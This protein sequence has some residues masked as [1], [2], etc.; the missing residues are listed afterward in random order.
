MPAYPGYDGSLL[1]FK[2]YTCLVDI[3]LSPNVDDLRDIDWAYEMVGKEINW[4]PLSSDSMWEWILPLWRLMTLEQKEGGTWSQQ[5]YV[6]MWLVSFMSG[7]I[8]LI[9]TDILPLAMVLG[10]HQGLESSS[11]AGNH[12]TDGGSQM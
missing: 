1:N 10:Y 4:S 9:L 2:L 7:Y 11:A 5:L 12:R 6:L 8:L 3:N